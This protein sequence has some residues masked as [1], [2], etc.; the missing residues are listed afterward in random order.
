M[1]WN[2]VQAH[3]HVQTSHNS[4]HTD[5]TL[6]T[7]TWIIW[8]VVRCFNKFNLF[9]HVQDAFAGIADEEADDDDDDDDEDEKEDVAD[10]AEV[11]KDGELGDTAKKDSTPKIVDAK[12]TVAF[13]GT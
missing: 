1:C 12:K 8:F 6:C 5:L 2:K 13:A 11:E 4:F 9:F 7:T 10:V 3:L